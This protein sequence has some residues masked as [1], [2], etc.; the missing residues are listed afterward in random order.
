MDSL[1]KKVNHL[2][3]PQDIHKEEAQGLLKEYESKG[4]LKRLNRQLLEYPL[5][6]T[7]NFFYRLSLLHSNKSPIYRKRDSRWIAQKDITRI[8]LKAAYTPGLKANFLQSAML[9]PALRTGAV[10]LDPFTES[11]HDSAIRLLSHSKI[12]KSLIIPELEELGFSGEQQLE[13]FIQA[14]HLCGMVVGLDLSF[15]LSRDAEALYRRP[16]LFRWIKLDPQRHHIPWNHLSYDE[17]LSEPQQEQICTEIKEMVSRPEMDVSDRFFMNRELRRAGYFPVPSN[18]E[19]RG[20]IPLFI[21][22][23][24]EKDEAVFTSHSEDLHITSFRFYK[25]DNPQAKGQYQNQ[26]IDY[27]SRIFSLWQPRGFDFLFLDG[28]IGVQEDEN[29][30]AFH[31]EGPDASI[32]KQLLDNV[33]A[34]KKSA[35]IIGSGKVEHL[36]ESLTLGFN[37]I[38]NQ[39]DPLRLD[40]GYI[41]K[42]LAQQKELKIFNQNRKIPGTIYTKLSLAEQNSHSFSQKV[43]L[44]HFCCRFMNCGQAGRRKFEMMG[45]NDGS[46]GYGAS[47]R[48]KSSLIWREDRGFLDKYHTLEDIFQKH[49]HTLDKGEIVDIRVDEHY[50]WWLIK[51]PSEMLAA[52]VSVENDEMLAPPLLELDLSN[53]M[54]EF[55]TPNILEY[56]F[57]SP[58]GNLVLTMSDFIEVYHLGYRG[59]RL[60]SIK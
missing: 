15:H 36:D 25:A 30:P 53:Y 5:T 42:S 12:D 28:A 26:T 22:Y 48:H 20:Y 49:S 18:R 39:E 52:V 56:D 37:S 38:V 27:F 21:V 32:L 55:Q 2:L 40:R 34:K 3:E 57:K 60:Y 41:E 43:H 35:G 14:A 58:S 11:E 45:I 1:W 59:Y 10:Q 54:K 8:N 50:A 47:L 19:N 4:C 16:E 7:A 31:A 9:L 24:N 6:V 13:C 33:R 23:D 44:E 46:A 51:G 29:Q 17:M